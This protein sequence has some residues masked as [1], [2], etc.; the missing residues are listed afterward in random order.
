MATN[1]QS[2]KR[3]KTPY[4]LTYWMLNVFNSSAIICMNE[5]VWILKSSK[6]NFILSRD[7]ESWGQKVFMSMYTKWNSYWFLYARP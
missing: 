1:P 6:S 7:L 3:S 2:S 4:V 5:Y